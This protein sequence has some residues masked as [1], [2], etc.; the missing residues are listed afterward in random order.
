SGD[1]F[2]LD[3]RTGKTIWTTKL[4]G[5]VKAAPAF[6]DGTLYVGDYAGQMYAIRASDGAIRWRTSDLGVG[7][8]Q[9]G[10]F[11]S[12]PAVAFGRVYAGNVDGRVYS[13]DQRSG[14]VAWTHSAG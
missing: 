12:T 14:E 1:F 11:Y 6:S 2:A 7:L 9:S 10:R 3:I 4:A 8:G 13:F 5:S